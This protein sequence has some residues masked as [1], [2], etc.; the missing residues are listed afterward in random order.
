VTSFFRLLLASVVVAAVQLSVLS[1]LR[2]AHV[3]IMIVW[4]WALA[5]GISIN[6]WFAAGGGALAGFILDAQSATPLFTFAVT[7]A[8]VGYACGRL[9]EEGIGDL[10]GAAWW[11]GPIVGSL[12][13]VVTVLTSMLVAIVAGDATFWRGNAGASMVVNMLAA[14]ISVRPLGRFA[15]WSVGDDYVVHR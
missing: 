15:R 4:V 1:P 11:S 8:L 5:L 9:G 14:A 10:D 3:T 12:G 7:G 6:R 13:I 2:V